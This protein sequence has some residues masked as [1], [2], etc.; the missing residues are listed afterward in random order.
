MLIHP[1]SSIEAPVRRARLLRWTAIGTFGAGLALRDCVLIAA[2]A[3]VA[4]QAFHLHMDA[5]AP[6]Q[7]WRAALRC[8]LAGVGGLVAAGALLAMVGSAWMGWWEPRSDH[9][10]LALLVLALAALACWAWQPGGRDRRFGAGAAITMLAGGVALLSASLGWP[11]ALCLFA[12]A[13]AVVIGSIGWTL[14]RST[15]AAL[16][17]ADGRR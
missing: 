10:L 9:P 6:W 1:P 15:A 14:L 7:G 4:L 11:V 3:L 8:A 16:T 5:N 17:V 2:S 12:F 13:A